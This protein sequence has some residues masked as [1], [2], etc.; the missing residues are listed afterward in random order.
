MSAFG[1]FSTIEFTAIGF[2]E[3]RVVKAGVVNGEFFDVMGLRPVLGR[4]LNASDDGPDAAPPSQER[5]VRELVV[6]C[7]GVATTNAPRPC[8]VV[9]T[10]DEAIP[11]VTTPFRD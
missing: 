6:R 7:E 2:G 9:G 3:P 5:G 1:E 4:L 8:S 10:R 11:A